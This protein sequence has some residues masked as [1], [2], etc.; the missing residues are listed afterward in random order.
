MNKTYIKINLRRNSLDRNYFNLRL[1]STNV[2]VAEV[3]NVEGY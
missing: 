1:S 3:R 2:N